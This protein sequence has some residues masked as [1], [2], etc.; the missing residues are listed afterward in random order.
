MVVAR[1]FPDE[2]MVSVLVSP[3]TGLT[4]ASPCVMSAEWWSQALELGTL[5]PSKYSRSA[6]MLVMW[7]SVQGL[8]IL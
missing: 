7:Q 8:V 4:M 2:K 6:L 1:S 5:A 3:H